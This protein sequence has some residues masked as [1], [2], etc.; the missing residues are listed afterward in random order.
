[1]LR[2]KTAHFFQFIIF[3][4]INKINKCGHENIPTILMKKMSCDITNHFNLKSFPLY[5]K[6]LSQIKNCIIKRKNNKNL[7]KLDNSILVENNIDSPKS[8][9]KHD[10]TQHKVLEYVCPPPPPP[11][12]PWHWIHPFDPK[13]VSGFQASQTL[14]CT[15]RAST[16]WAYPQYF[17][18]LWTHFK[19]LSNVHPKQ[20]WVWAGKN[21]T[22][23][24]AHGP[25]K[26]K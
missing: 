23:K 8:T 11:P 24:S 9:D 22:H 14:T 17:I 2:T 4:F 15:I 25:S 6:L 7:K 19:I 20:I 3:K 16:F 21:L 1:M 10:R 5:G 26:S 18:Y 12:P 13:T